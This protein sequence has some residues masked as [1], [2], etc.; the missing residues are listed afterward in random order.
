MSLKKGFL[1]VFEGIDGA[2]K[3]TQAGLLFDNLIRRGF[4]V[5]LSKEPTDDTIHGLKIKKLAEGERTDTTPTDE[6]SLFL[7]DRKIHVENVIKPALIEKKIVILDRYYFSNIAYQGALGLDPQKIKKDNESF[8]PKPEVVFFLRMPAHIGIRRIQKSRPEKPNL[9]EQ[10][11]YLTKVER[12]FES[13]KEN[14]IVDINGTEGIQEV[15]S[16]VMNVIE[17]ILDHYLNK[18]EQYTIFKNHRSQNTA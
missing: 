11:D 10:E 8:A 17:D 7:N 18:I 9:F 15:H 6:Y 5:V 13:M 3:T 12:V 4:S 16:T 14:Y 1:V 2:G